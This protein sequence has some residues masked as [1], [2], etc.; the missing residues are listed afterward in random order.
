M[1]F[2]IKSELFEMM[3][4]IVKSFFNFGQKNAYHII[5]IYENCVISI[6]RDKI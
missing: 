1:R 2:G 3:S 5:F 6:F 4:M